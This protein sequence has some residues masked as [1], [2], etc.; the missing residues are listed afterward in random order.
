MKK[1]AYNELFEEEPVIITESEI[2]KIHINRFNDKLKK[3][4]LNPELY[5]E[6]DCIGDWVTEYWAWE[7]TD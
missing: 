2:L 7:Y 1:Y 4:K 3:L 6:Q 5:T